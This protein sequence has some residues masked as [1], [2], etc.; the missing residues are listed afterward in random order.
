MTMS[1]EALISLE[2]YLHTSYDPDVEYV[3][4][5]L[6]ERNVGDWLASTVQSNLIFALRSRYPQKLV[7]QDRVFAIIAPQGAT[8]VVAT[9][10]YLEENKVPLLFP[11]QGSTVTR[12]RRWV[13]QGMMVSDRMSKMIEKLEEYD[14]KAIRNIWLI[15]P[16]LR[17]VAVY[18]SGVLNEVRGRR[19]ATSCEPLFEL[20]GDEIFQNLE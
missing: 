19:I 3:D 2:E 6:V 1:V 13:V 11:Y 12:G 17:K 15:D 7:E 18:S 4:G 16:R 14:R 10:K 5:L 8:P 20:S 9:L